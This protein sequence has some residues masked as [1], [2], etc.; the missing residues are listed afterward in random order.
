MIRDLRTAACCVALCLGL[1]G[2]GAGAEGPRGL[3]TAWGD[4]DLAGVW[5]NATLTPLERPD[6]VERERYTESEVAALEA[7]TAQR[8][9]RQDGATPIAGSVGGYNNVYLDWGVKVVPGG[10]TSLIVD[11]PDGKIPWIPEAKAASDRERARYGVG[12]YEA[13]EDFDTGERCLSDGAT[14]APLMPYNMN[15]RILQTPDHVV[16][17]QEMYHE[18]RIVPLSDVSR[19]DTS[20]GYAGAWLGEPRGRW[21]DDTLVIE[22][23]HYLPKQHYYWAWPWRASRSS[24]RTVE[25]LRRVDETT[26]DYS[27]TIE[28][29][30]SFTRPWTASAPMTTDHASRGVSA[31][32]LHE[33]ACHEGNYALGNMLRGA[34]LAEQEEPATGAGPQQP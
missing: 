21:E 31:G 26:L 33:Y 9:A 11:P 25:R 17:W 1:P 16:I 4:P 23:E 28:D 22:T 13:P 27:F 30:T 12:P 8:I 29:P 18:V 15:Y 5:T 7:R 10:R 3:R 24:L 2:I 14:M 19:L 32:A 6:G 20:G 34:R